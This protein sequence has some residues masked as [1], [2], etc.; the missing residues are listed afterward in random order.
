MKSI[1]LM[2]LALVLPLGAFA[3]EKGIDWKPGTSVTSEYKELTGSVVLKEKAAPVL[4]VG[5]D[6]YRLL[7]GRR[8]PGR[9][10][11]KNGQSITVKGVATTVVVTGKPTKTDTS[12]V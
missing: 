8:D 3:Q 1:W 2:T 7:V 9:Q 12:P 4:K 10:A 11:L 6:D 5:S